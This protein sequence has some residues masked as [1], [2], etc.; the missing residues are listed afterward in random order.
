MNDERMERGESTL[1]N[2]RRVDFQL[3][4]LELVI[5]MNMI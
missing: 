2:L 1:E 4:L 5:K 3:E